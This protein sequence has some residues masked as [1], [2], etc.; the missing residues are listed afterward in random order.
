MPHTVHGLVPILA[1]PF[2]PDGALDLPSLRRLTEFQLSSGV[3]GVAVFGMASEGFALTTDERTRILATV[4]DVVA[5]AVPIVAGVNGTSTVTAIEQ[6]DAAMAGGANALMVLPPFMVKP[7]PDQL[8]AFYGEVA[9]AASVEVM[10]QDAPGATGVTMAPSLI[11]ELGKLDGVTSVKVESPPTAPKVAAVVAARADEGFAVLGGQNAQFCLEEYARGAIGTMP[12]CEFPDLLA[13]VLA[14][15]EAGRHAEARA[16][17]TRLLPLILFGLQQGIAWAVHKEV[18]VR[19]G[20]IADAT[21]RSPARP[22]DAAG[23]E[24]LS[25]ILADLELAG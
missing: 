6:A 2:G 9:S 17:F 20:L 4:T 24:S 10:V 25:A 7:T 15:W 5:G 22:L 21:V 1:T 13:P 19:R 11:A 16:A 18:L 14:D 23:R 12:A 3:T 8:L